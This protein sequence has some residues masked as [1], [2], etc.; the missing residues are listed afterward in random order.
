MKLFVP[1]NIKSLVPYPPGKPLEE[2]E[3]EY[4]ISNSIKMASN[5][6]SLGPSPKAVEAISKALG[7]L[8]RYPD[9][10]CYYLATRLAEKLA[11]APEELIF[12]NGSDEI[13][14][15]LAATF[16]QAGDEAISS[17]PSFLV[18]TTVVQ[19]HGGIN[20]IIPLKNMSHD[21][22]TIAAAVTAKTRLIFLDNPNN[23][24]GTIFSTEEFD[25]FLLKIPEHV[26]VVLDEAYLD[27][28]PPEQQIDA[29]RYLKA[30]TP[31]VA[32]RTFSKAYGIAGLRVGY[33]IMPAELAGFVHRV[34]APFNVN[35]LAQ[36]GAIAALDDI[37]H[38]EKTLAMTHE[39]IVWLTEQFSSMGL[40]CYPTNTNFFLVDINRECKSFYDAM[41]RKGVIVRPMTAYGFPEFIRITVG[42][43]AENQ[44]LLLAVQECLKQ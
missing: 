3:R 44:R 20:T 43:S 11:I 21:L 26:V 5:E 23:P 4:G 33:G 6:N 27:F 34:R 28:V 2:L 32:L 41:L 22:S 31:V 14:A 24:T 8:H 10:S 19:A 30:K 38:Y 40:K 18:Y 39:G 29:R 36:I 15:M 13:I 7:N 37:D 9:G 17:H 25:D 42:T 35:Q 1:E 16:L 12:G